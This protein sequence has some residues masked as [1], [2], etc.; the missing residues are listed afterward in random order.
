MVVVYDVVDRCFS[1]FRVAQLLLLLLLLSLSLLLS[2]LLLLL[3]GQDT[4]SPLKTLAY[5]L[6]D[7]DPCQNRKLSD[8]FMFDI[9]PMCRETEVCHFS[10]FHAKT[11]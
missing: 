11:F 4:N 3:S 7:I 9:H 5:V 10:H 2:V 6:L 1:W 8:L